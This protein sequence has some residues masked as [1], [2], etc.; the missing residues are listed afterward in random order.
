VDPEISDLI[1]GFLANKRRDAGQIIAAAEAADFPALLGIGHKIK[2]E[3]G[4]YGLD[5]ISMLGAQIELAAQQKDLA[6]VRR[7]AEEL[8]NYLDTVEIVYK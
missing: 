5:G 6:A 1:P 4:S 3:G 2:G 7:Y 8:S